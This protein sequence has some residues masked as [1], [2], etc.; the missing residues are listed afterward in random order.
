VEHFGLRPFIR[1]NTSVLSVRPAPDYD[2]TGRYT[3]RCQEQGHAPVDE[4]FDCVMACSGHHWKPRTPSFPGLDS[5]RGSTL[6][7]HA[8]KDHRGYEDKHVAVVGVGNSGTA[9]A[10]GAVPHP[11]R[12]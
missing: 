9:P 7:A 1:F 4:V 10:L 6:H 11:Y 8:Y 5:F 3:V 12:H 2:A